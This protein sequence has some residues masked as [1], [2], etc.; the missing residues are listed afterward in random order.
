MLAARYENT[1]RRVITYYMLLSSYA[2]YL[3]NSCLFENFEIPLNIRT[4]I[5]SAVI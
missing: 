2:I 3:S 1:T 4:F 5:L